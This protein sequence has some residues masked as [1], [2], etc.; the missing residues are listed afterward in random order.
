MISLAD[1]WLWN[2]DAA[3]LV[4]EAEP[5]WIPY[6]LSYQISYAATLISA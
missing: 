5:K 1:V 4:P 6:P 3:A 2:A